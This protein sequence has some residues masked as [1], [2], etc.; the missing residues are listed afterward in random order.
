MSIKTPHFFAILLLAC[1]HPS[2]H[3]PLQ[4]ACRAR[5]GMDFPR[6]SSLLSTLHRQHGRGRQ[7]LCC[8]SSRQELGHLPACLCRANTSRRTALAFRRRSAGS[9][10]APLRLIL[11][12]TLLLRSALGDGQDSCRDLRL[13]IRVRCC[14]RTLPAL[15]AIATSQLVATTDAEYHGHSRG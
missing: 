6:P 3:T 2:L 4:V 13:R 11:L 15:A 14:L 1:L 9:R 7:G 12:A 8:D 10:L 5:A